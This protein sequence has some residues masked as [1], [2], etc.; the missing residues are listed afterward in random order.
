MASGKG[1]Y[2]CPNWDIEL[3]QESKGGYNILKQEQQ[4][5]GK[6]FKWGKGGEKEKQTRRT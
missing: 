3:M 5:W 1:F 4:R 2:G 6:F